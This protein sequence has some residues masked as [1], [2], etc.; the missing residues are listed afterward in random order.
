MYIEPK[1]FHLKHFQVLQ[2]FTDA[3]SNETE[4]KPSSFSVSSPKQGSGGIQFF[5]ELGK[6]WFWSIFRSKL[7]YEKN[8]TEI[9]I[10]NCVQLD[11]LAFV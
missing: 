9:K 11:I 7:N 8:K 5:E 1:M 3:T 4:K 2:T 10:K 6:D